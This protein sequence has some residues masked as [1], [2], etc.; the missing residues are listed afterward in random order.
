MGRPR[1]HPLP[2]EEAGSLIAIESGFWTAPDGTP[3]TFR[4]GETIVARDHPLVTLGNPDWFKPVEPNLKRPAVEQMTASP[5]E[6][7]GEETEARVS[8]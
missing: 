2:L 1:K 4:A 3:Y 6:S 8:A 7:R 5:G